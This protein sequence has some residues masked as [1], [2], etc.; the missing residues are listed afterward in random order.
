M[1]VPPPP[2]APAPPPVTAIDLTEF[3]AV[4]DTARID[5]ERGLT[6]AL[7]AVSGDGQPDISL[8]GS[9]MVWDKDHLA[10]WE[11]TRRETF[12]LLQRDPHVVAFVRNPVRDRRYFRFYGEARL[13]DDADLRE[14]IW[15]RTLQVERDMDKDKQGVAVIVR[16]DRV[17]AGPFE[18]QRR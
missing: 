3:A 9:L 6:T 4:V 17:R 12:A 18:I 15:Q 14:Q 7:V 16:V 13:V 10:W 5:D 2:A 11:R 8:K 1:A